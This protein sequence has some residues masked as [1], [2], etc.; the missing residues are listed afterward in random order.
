[1]KITHVMVRATEGDGSKMVAI[2]VE[3]FAKLFQYYHS[4]PP[5]YAPLRVTPPDK[6]SESRGED[7]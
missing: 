1:M 3:E 5:G 4:F 6:A 7:T 2:P